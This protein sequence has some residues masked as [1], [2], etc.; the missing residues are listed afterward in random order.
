MN[1]L[2]KTLIFT[3]VMLPI[4][5]IAG[6]FLA[7]YQIEMF[8]GPIMDEAIAEIG[9]K[10]MLIAVTVAQ[11]TVYAAIFGFCGY[12]LSDKLGLIRSFSLKGQA[13]KKSLLIICCL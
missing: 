5:C 10:E 7:I 6:Y 4:A 12:L 2:K 8:A 13:L 9:S 11:N 1:E 3:A